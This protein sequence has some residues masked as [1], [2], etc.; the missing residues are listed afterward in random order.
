MGNMSGNL[1]GSMAP[2]L[3]PSVLTPQGLPAAE[4]LGMAEKALNEKRQKVR[5]ATV[6]SLLTGKKEKDSLL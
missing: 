4:P 3:T 2:A 1:L 6:T 5:K